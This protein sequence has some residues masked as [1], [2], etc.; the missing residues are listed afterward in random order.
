M[1]RTLKREAT[2]PAAFNFLEYDLGYF[3][4]EDRAKPSP[5]PLIPDKM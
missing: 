2:R 5:S 1:H 4:K 3:D